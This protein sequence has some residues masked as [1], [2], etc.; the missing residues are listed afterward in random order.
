MA[1]G[2][3]NAIWGGMI[4]CALLTELVPSLNSI[5][6]HGKCRSTTQFSAISSHLCQVPK[7]YFRHLYYL[8]CLLSMTFF[9]YS[10]LFH[11]S[12][13]HILCFFLWLLHN[14]RRLWETHFIT[15]YG[16]STMHIGGYLAG[17]LHY[18]ITPI[19]FYF[20]SPPLDQLSSHQR[21]RFLSA[22]CLFLWAS[23]TQHNCHLILYNI[24]VRNLNIPCRPIYEVPTQSYFKYI[25]CPHYLA[26]ILVYLSF[27]LLLHFDP[28]VMLLLVWVTTN[29]SVVA[30]RHYRWYLQNLPTD[31]PHNWK[32]LVPLIW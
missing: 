7:S 22:I 14:F 20:A 8:G 5:S 24:K 1:L 19:T 30:N 21:L 16:S 9:Y 15:I 6:T 18:M 25:C 31:V 32:R 2:I 10:I 27:L 12:L 4:L 29:L 28:T 23:W 3:L 17:L 13:Q 11:F 26:E